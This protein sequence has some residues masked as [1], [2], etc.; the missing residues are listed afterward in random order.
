MTYQDAIKLKEASKHLLGTTD[1][2]GY[3]IGNVLIVPSDQDLRNDFFLQYQDNHDADLCLKK[4][5]CD[6]FIVIGID[7]RYFWDQGWLFFNVIQ[8][9]MSEA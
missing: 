5:L 4:F 9:M 7:E 6:D 2:K 1:S 8:P 3:T